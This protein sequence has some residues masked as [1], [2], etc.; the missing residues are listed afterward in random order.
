MSFSL[1]IKY[2]LPK[3]EIC[4]YAEPGCRISSYYRTV[5]IERNREEVSAQLPADSSWLIGW[6][7]LARR[8]LRLDKCNVYPVGEDL[9]ELI[10]IRRGT[11]YHYNALM[12]DL[13]PV[14]SL[15]NCRNLLHQSIAR[16][17][18]DEV[19]FGEYGSNPKRAPVPV[20]RSTDR[21]RSW[22]T[23]FMFPE[24][25]I[26]HVHGCYWDPYEE[27][28]WVLT[29][30]ANS[31]CYMIVADREFNKV[32]WLGDDSQVWRACNVFFEK[33]RVVWLM[34]AH[35]EDSHLIIY[36]RKSGAINK[37]DVLPGPVWYIKRLID[38]HYLAA[39]ACEIGPGV[40]DDYAHLL[41]ST[42]L[43]NWK[44]IA[45]FRHDG[46]PKGYFKFGVIGFADGA[47]SSKEFYIFGEALRG[48]DGKIA[49]CSL[50][51]NQYG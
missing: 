26:K 31:E 47:Q 12:D 27:K 38:G 4:H 42:N 46:L 17:G 1:K 36:D 23:V 10:I 6:S 21:G 33:D 44:E 41:H 7:R 29:G 48:L 24:K 16:V 40:H 11:V 51:A 2:H 35:Q 30:D 14:L 3:R 50:E 43:E 18:F 25:S 34:D 9:D 28:I 39:T 37:R 49:V 8:S 20:Y 22:K 32:K 45:R 19:F 15:Q 13:R 5:F